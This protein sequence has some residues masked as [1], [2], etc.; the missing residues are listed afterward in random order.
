MVQSMVLGWAFVN[1]VQGAEYG[2]R[3]G[4]S[5]HGEWCRAWSKGGML[6][7]WCMVRSMVQGWGYGEWCGVWS[8]SG[9]LLMW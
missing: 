6:L 4:Y 9:L 7:R 2:P 3:V 8:K 5:E 1:M